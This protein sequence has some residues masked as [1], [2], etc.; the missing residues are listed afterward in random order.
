MSTD[1]ALVVG[2][3]TGALA[4]VAVLTALIE[5]RRPR[6]AA[7]VVVMSGGLILW[8]AGASADGFQWDDVPNAF[9]RVIAE[10]LN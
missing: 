8:G 1:I 7:L 6:V 10:I 2:T 9:V 3:I 5:G 4:L